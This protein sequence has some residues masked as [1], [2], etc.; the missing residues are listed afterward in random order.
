MYPAVI[1]V[2]VKIFKEKKAFKLGIIVPE[3]SSRHTI[4]VL[5]IRAF[6]TTLSSI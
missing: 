6:H 3:I 4:L 2:L 1:Y 5:G